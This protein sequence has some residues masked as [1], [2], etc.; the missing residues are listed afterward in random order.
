M[1]VKN[2][3]AVKYMSTFLCFL[4]GCSEPQP[5]VYQ[6]TGIKIGEVTDSEVI[7]WT[8][9]TRNAERVGFGAPVPD[10]LYIHPDSGELVQDP[11]WPATPEDWIPVVEYPDG[12]TIETIE[13]SVPGMPGE[14]R[15]LYR[16]VDS[17]EWQMTSWAA[18][19]VDRD[20]TKQF[21][22]NG[23]EA[24]TEY[25]L[26]VEARSDGEFNASSVLSGSFR[27]APN[28]EE[29]ARVVFA[30]TTGQAYPDQDAV[31]GGFRIYPS[32]LELS[33]SFFVHTGDI[34]Y[35]DQWA[36]N[37]DLARWGWARMFSLPTNFDFHRKI[38]TYF[39][40]DDHDTWSNDSW[41]TQDSRFMGDF[42]FEHGQ[43][44]FLEQIPMGELTYRTFQW[45]KDL[46]IWLVENRDYRSANT[47][48][49]GPEKTIWGLEQKSWFMDS[50][51]A[52][53]AT[54]RILIT[55]T[56]M[57]GPYNEGEIDNHTN[58]E[59]FFYEGE[60]IR[61]FL[62]SQENIFVITG[63]RHYQYVIQD[64]ETGLK[65]FATG[66]ASDPH[67]RG[68]S[69]DDIRPEHRYL[70]IVGGFLTATIEQSAEG[71]ILI[72]RHHD[73]DGAVLNEDLNMVT[74]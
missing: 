47:D 40:K 35:Y 56:P 37:L 58:L 46:Q 31:G 45:G 38:P 21:Y 63:D 52:S 22:I 30:A 54:F 41:P 67:A 24:S 3:K 12:A 42:T 73:V 69:A 28:S 4:L 66:P 34:L 70:N 8:R 26:Q 5:T 11:V 72:F 25:E 62:A 51:Q 32:I 18:V 17:N 1:L 14:T 59:G 13:G 61:Q 71:P 10:T 48:P 55:P 9:I 57:L 39:M 27:T 16:K 33:P 2:F 20:F 19:D 7:I 23:L 64:P 74:R 44:V 68:W 53:T 15:V 60:E 36:K 49:D 50:V 6:A 65:E 29:P 43:A